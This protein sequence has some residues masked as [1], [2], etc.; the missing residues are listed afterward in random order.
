MPFFLGTRAMLGCTKKANMATEQTCPITLSLARETK[1]SAA[2]MWLGDFLRSSEGRGYETTAGPGQPGCSGSWA[3][4]CHGA[5]SPPAQ[6]HPL[7]STTMFWT[8]IRNLLLPPLHL[9]TTE[10]PACQLTHQKM[11]QDPEAHGPQKWISSRVLTQPQR[12]TTVE[13]ERMHQGPSTSEGTHRPLQLLSEGIPV[14]PWLSP[15]CPGRAAALPQSTDGTQPIYQEKEPFQATSHNDSE[16]ESYFSDRWL[17]GT[18]P[19][20]SHRGRMT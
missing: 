1:P 8:R 11:C 12:H 16:H 18:L 6:E 10:A 3:V 17:T 19:C 2:A 20:L 4:A 15:M 5:H 9:P 13:Q 7:P 14:G